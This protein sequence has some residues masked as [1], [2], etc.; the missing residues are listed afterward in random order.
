[1]PSLQLSGQA[2]AISPLFKK[3]SEQEA[4]SSIDCY[5]GKGL[6][7]VAFNSISI[8]RVSVSNKGDPDTRQG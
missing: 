7:Q 3:E 6:G 5:P 8:I 2:V 1:M 4:I